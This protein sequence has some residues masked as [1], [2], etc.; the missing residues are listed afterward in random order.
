MCL[1]WGLTSPWKQVS[2]QEAIHDIEIGRRKYF[3]QWPERRTV[4]LAANGQHGKYLRT[5]GVIIA[6]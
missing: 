1:R 3:V 4:V 6:N 5:D 2:S